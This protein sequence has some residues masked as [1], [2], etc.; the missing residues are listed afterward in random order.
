MKKQ[1]HFDSNLLLSTK[2]H[3][4]LCHQTPIYVCTYVSIY[5]GSFHPV[6]HLCPVHGKNN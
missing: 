1:S 4:A 6:L 3:C 5:L 2:E